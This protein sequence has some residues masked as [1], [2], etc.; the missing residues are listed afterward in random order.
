MVEVGGFMGGHELDHAQPKPGRRVQ[1]NL[2]KI[3]HNLKFAAFTN[4]LG[5][6]NFIAQMPVK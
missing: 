4:A 2:L 5:Y 6:R 1:N 3:L